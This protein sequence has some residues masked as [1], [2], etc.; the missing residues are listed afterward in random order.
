[1]ALT[2]STD[3]RLGTR[4]AP[5]SLPDAV[6]GRVYTLD[7]LCGK[8]ATLIMFIC[9]HC[10]YVKHVN[11]ELIRLAHDVQ[12]RGVGVIA[13]SS[14]DVRTYPEDAP[15]RMR[16][17]AQRLGYPFPYLFDATQEV[18]RTYDAAC[19]P[20]FYVYDTEL[21]L[22]YHGRLDDST[23]GNG[24]PV[25]GADLRAAIDALLAGHEPLATQHPS[26]GCSIKFRGG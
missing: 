19:T 15:E 2:A 10:P 16:E 22:K 26:L 6:S 5:F 24:R 8:H 12:P 7:Q 1:M 3:V 11:L 20:D 17:T 4:A 14:N 9:N 25:T 13:V 23:P 18:A 21:S